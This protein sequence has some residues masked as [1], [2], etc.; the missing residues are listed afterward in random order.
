MNFEKYFQKHNVLTL[1]N[2]WY[3]TQQGHIFQ[4][5]VRARVIYCHIKKD[6]VV[7]KTEV[8]QH[9]PLGDL[10]PKDIVPV[11][12]KE[13]LRIVVENDGRLYVYLNERSAQNIRQVVFGKKCK[14]RCKEKG[15]YCPDHSLTKVVLFSV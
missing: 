7:I 13:G 5:S 8:Q 12:R 9:S 14:R 15:P 2:V 4:C 3:K 10:I 6:Q 11:M 1:H